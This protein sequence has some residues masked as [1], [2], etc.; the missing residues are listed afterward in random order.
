MVHMQPVQFPISVWVIIGPVVLAGVA[1][2]L[3][4][5]AFQLAAMGAAPSANPRFR[6]R[7]RR[8]H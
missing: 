2:L 7:T 3:V 6:N 8:R 1:L 4:K 5:M